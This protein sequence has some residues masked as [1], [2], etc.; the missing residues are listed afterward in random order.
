LNP[1]WKGPAQQAAAGFSQLDTRHK[2][3]AHFSPYIDM[4]NPNKIF[5]AHKNISRYLEK[6][7]YLHENGQI[8]RKI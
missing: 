3:K 1:G 8:Y 4:P 7:I 5:R 2:V 6:Y